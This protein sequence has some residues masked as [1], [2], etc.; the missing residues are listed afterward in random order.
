[1][2]QKQKLQDIL[3]KLKSWS[4]SSGDETLEEHIKELET[5][6]NASFAAQGDSEE[7]EGGNSPSDPPGLP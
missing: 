1:M 3:A 6:I 2:S 5:Q 4:E 7:G